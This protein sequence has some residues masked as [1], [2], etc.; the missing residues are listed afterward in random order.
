MKKS[1]RS[2]KSMSLGRSLAQQVLKDREKAA[3]RRKRA[4]AS[5]TESAS[6]R[7]MFAHAAHPGASAGVLIAEG[8]SWFNYPFHDVLRELEDG[9]GYD[10]EST[11]HWGDKVEDMAY[12]GGQLDAF[13]RCIEKVLRSNIQPRAILLSGGGNDVAGDE[14]GMLI[15]HFR[16]GA[17][18]LN[19]SI[20]TGVIQ[21]RVLNAYV[22]ILSAV[23]EISKQLIGHA[24]PIIVHGYDYAVPDGRGVLG[25]FGPLPGPWLEP[26]FRAKGY[27]DLRTRK[28]IIAELMDRFNAMLSG[29]AGKPPFSHVNYLNLRGTLSTGSHYKDWWANELHPTPNGFKTVASKFA[30]LLDSFP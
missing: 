30:A 20:V 19:N 4:L 28:A 12:S 22:T 17:P 7:G 27:E 1:K 23:T 26:G 16:S 10:I 9:F 3:A 6:S 18:G 11:A 24:I 8:D 21:E 25:G 15:N 5:L 29:L 14:F 2:V 13:T